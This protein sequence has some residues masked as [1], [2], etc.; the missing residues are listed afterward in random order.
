MVRKSRAFLGELWRLARPYWFSEEKGSARL[1]LAAI[2]ALTLAM[3][4]LSV[5]F[6]S[7]YNAFYNALQ[8]KDKTE[9]FHQMGRFMWLAG[10]YIVIAVYAVYL[11]Q[12]LQIRWRRWMTD[13]YLTDWLGERTYYRMQLRGNGTD[14]PDQRIAEDMNL[15]VAQTLDLSL[16]LLNAVVTFVSFVGILWG[17]SGSLE[18]GFGGKTY[19]IYG[20]MVWVA[21]VYAVIGSWLTHRLGFPLV[22]LN[23]DQQRY[24]ADF[25]FGLARFR[26]NTEGVALYRGE[27]DEM[28][29]FRGRFGNV[30][31]NWWRIMKRQKL[32]NFYTNGYSQV[33][34]VFPF[35]VGAPRYFSGAIPLGGLI[36]ISNAFGQVQGALSWFINAYTTF[37]EWRAAVERLTGFH[38][39]IA[40][41]KQASAPQGLATERTA[42]EVLSVEGVAIALPDGRSLLRQADMKILPGERVIVRGPS[43]SGKSTLFRTLAGIWPFASG[44]MKVPEDFEPLFLPQRPYFPL[45]TLRQAVAYPAAAEVFGDERIRA[46][47]TDV[48]LPHLADRLDETAIWAQQLSGGEQQRVAFARALLHEP[49]WLFL[50]EATS[51]LDESSEHRLYALLEERLP[52]TA[53][54]SIAHRPGPS[55]FHEHALELDPTDGG[56]LRAHEQPVPA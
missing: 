31:G 3:V 9:F 37:A 51:N 33:A 19:E 28:A 34:V 55:R 7:W 43:G 47:L 53:I 20:Y 13:R 26:E 40:D 18:F 10:I 46:T 12:M 32:L 41:A 52:H 49:R 17:L 6:N 23:F 30:L 16:G 56:T 48:G 24:E 15:F 2:V 21:I 36:Q 29:G 38:N 14:N 8:N 42:S 4:Y 44:K 25:R 50:D 22:R 45:G 27:A 54:V 35:L 39:A 1:L 5:Q 11:R